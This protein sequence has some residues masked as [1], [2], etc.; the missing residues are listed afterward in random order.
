MMHAAYVYMIACLSGAAGAATPTINHSLAL[1]GGAIVIPLESNQPLVEED[2][3]TTLIFE[4]SIVTRPNAYLRWIGTEPRTE[5]AWSSGPLKT[6]ITRSPFQDAT[7]CLVVALPADGQGDLYVDGT[8]V[9]LAWTTLPNAMPAI[10]HAASWDGAPDTQPYAAPPWD[11]PL[12][13]WRCELLTLIGAGDRPADA[14]LSDV[15]TKLISIASTGP[16]RLAMHNIAAV[17]ESVA[18]RVIELLTGTATVDSHVIAAWLTAGTPLEELLSLV[19]TRVG[20]DDTL[21]ARVLRWCDRQT[22]ML[23][24]I[25]ADR[26]DTV[27][28]SLV[29]PGR[30]GELAEIAWAIP[31]ELPLATLVPAGEGSITRIDPLPSEE[32]L[33]LLV[34]VGTNHLGLGVDRVV[35]PVEPPGAMLGPLHPTRTLSDVRAASSPPLA[36]ASRRT[37][38]QLR[39][40]LGHW[41]IMLECRWP[42]PPTNTAS[43]YRESV[44]IRLVYDNTQRDI[45]V[46]PTG[47][48]SAHANAPQPRVHVNALEH[49][50]LC[51]VV[52]PQEWISPVIS[53]ALLRT[54]AD[55]PA[56]ET[57]PTPC[58]PWRMEFDPTP[59]NLNAW[60]QNVVPAGS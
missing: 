55:S 5:R 41:E 12:A 35:Q 26:G 56:F 14:E 44:T 11:D 1:R 23:A 16:W 60:D 25:T 2:I 58:A 59:F 18:R 24:W 3:S 7:A 13:T 22:S 28:L 47:L 6:K 32:F 43:R 34:E 46:S 15:A 40:V 29:N 42:H 38:A 8:V 45:V 19:L 20:T 48:Q 51:R 50:W 33:P 31:G 57:W 10:E 17:D 37:F 9:R 30:R 4:G 54:H 27:L 36:G 39:R 21:A 53:I 52:I 49:A